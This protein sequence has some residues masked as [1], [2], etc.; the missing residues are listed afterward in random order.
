MPPVRVRIDLGYDGGD[1]PGWAEQPGR[2]TV[3][4]TSRRRCDHAAGRGSSLTV[5][6]R[7]DAGVHARAQVGARRPSDAATTRHH[8]ARRLTG[9]CRRRARTTGLGRRR[10]ASTRGSPRSGGATP[11]GSATGRRGGPA[12]APSR[13]RAGRGRLDHDAMNGSRGDPRGARLRG[14]LQAAR[15][16]TTIRALRELCWER[17]PDGDL[18]GTVGQTRSAT[19][20]SGP[21]SGRWSPSG[22]AGRRRLAVSCCRPVAGPGA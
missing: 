8:A 18:V 20:W 22:R 3:Q 16:A 21:S 14:V 13:P 1:F 9:C 19:T 15:G 12:R 10:P 4:G 17:Q 7:T 11:I 6:G 5:A 2:R